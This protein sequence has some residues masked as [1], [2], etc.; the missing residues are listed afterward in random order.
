MQLSGNTILITGGSEGIGFELARI[1]IPDNIVIIC[2]RSEEKLARTKSVLPQLI[3]EVCNVTDEGGRDEL[4]RRVLL[5][6]PKLNVLVNNAGGRRRVDLRTGDG[7]DSALD[8]D[9]ALNFIAPAALCGKL[10]PH[11]QAQPRA[12]IVNI[13]TGLVYLPKAVQP[14]YCAAKAALHSYTQ[15]LRFAMQGSPVRVFEVFMTLVDTNFHQGE[16]PGTIKAMK[17][18]EAAL[19]TV[20]GIRRDKEEIYIG[21]AALARWLAFA[22][23][24]KGMAILNSRS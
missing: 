12:A 1:L 7:V 9:L 8:S 4:I 14:F 3:T 6:N 11:L 23:P 22:A 17:P 15:S 24:A 20:Q 16:L 10:L 18:Q 21:K 2:G 19:Q 5:G 13:S